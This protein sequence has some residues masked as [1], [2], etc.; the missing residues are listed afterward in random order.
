MLPV[1]SSARITSGLRIT[2]R[3]SAARCRSPPESSAGSAP[4]PAAEIDPF[5]QRLADRSARA[6]GAD[7]ADPER[8]RDVLG[9]RQVVEKVRSPAAPRR[10][11]GA[12]WQSHC[13]HLRAIGAAEEADLPGGRRQVE[14]SRAGEAWSC[15]RRTAPMQ[16]MERPGGERQAQ[17][18]QDR[19]RAIAEARLLEF[20]HPDPLRRLPRELYS[21]RA[22]RNVRRDARRGLEWPD[23][24]ARTEATDSAAPGRPP[25][26]VA[27]RLTCPNCGAEYDVA[28]GMVPAAGRHVQ[29]TACHTR[30]FVARRPGAGADR[31][32]DPAPARDPVPRAAARCP[33]PRRRLAATP[34]PHRGARRGRRPPTAAEPEAEPH[35]RSAADAARW[36]STCRRAGAAPAKPGDRPTVAR[37]PPLADLP[38]AA[39]RRPRR[40]EL[41]EPAA[42]AAPSAAARARSRFGRGLLARAGPRRA[43][44]RGLP[45]P[46]ADRRAGAAAARRSPPTATPSTAGAPRSRRASPRSA[47]NRP[48]PA[49]VTFRGVRFTDRRV[50]T[51]FNPM[52]S[53]QMRASRHRREPAMQGNPPRARAASEQVE[54]P[55]QVVELELRPP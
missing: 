27:M 24:A 26:E 14:R 53:S 36:S 38:P 43:G 2:A 44:A 29:C 48:T 7:A 22:R 4:R 42:R 51:A 54:Q 34:G 10:P 35:P 13:D 1:G 21:R 11:R 30:W 52:Q 15:R 32:P 25:T 40:L 18:V 23:A 28:D 5:E 37:P 19:R 12:G 31:G 20:D 9:Q 17:V 47:A 46:R 3:A 49:A 8:Q 33:P 41:G 6:S 55:P 50:H 39:A 45:L 16:E